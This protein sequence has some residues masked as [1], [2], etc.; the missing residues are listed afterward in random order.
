MTGYVMV[1]HAVRRLVRGDRASD[2]AP[3][4]RLRS[5]LH[6]LGLRFQ[7]HSPPLAGH[8]F[9]A[10]AV[11]P[12]ER[13]AVFVRRCFWHNC[14]AH[15]VL[16]GTQKEWW[17]AELASNVERDAEVNRALREHGWF[18]V[19]IWEHDDLPAAAHE[20]RR[21]VRDRSARL[22]PR[23]DQARHARTRRVGRAPTAWQGVRYSFN[24]PCCDRC[25]G[26]RDPQVEALLLPPGLETC[27]FCGSQTTAGVYVR[28]DPTAVPHPTIK[29]SSASAARGRW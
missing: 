24:Q 13:V 19:V 10:D 5:E 18:P 17:A 4:R 22:V 29:R 8:R 20:V 6:W 14:P 26:E 2:A 3:E 1:Q 15:G 25:L 12:T 28:V 9:T 21:I 23:L 27:C 16:P 7:E 11:F